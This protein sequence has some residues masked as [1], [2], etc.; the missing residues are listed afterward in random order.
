MRDNNEFEKISKLMTNLDQYRQ[1][2]KWNSM[3]TKYDIFD[4]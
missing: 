1:S 3:Q 2:V 4:Y